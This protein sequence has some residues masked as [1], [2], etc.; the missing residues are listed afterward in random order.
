MKYS[1]HPIPQSIADQVR[2]TMRSPGY[3]HPAH[4][5]VARGTGPCRSC[6]RPFRVGEDERILFTY[7]PFDD[8]G[9]PS[10]GPVF[11]HA[12]SCQRHEGAALPSELEAIPLVLEA[13]SADGRS[14]GRLA[15]GKRDPETAMTELSL[16]TGAEYFHLR[17]AEAGCFI[18]RVELLRIHELV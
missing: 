1:V 16:D 12:E 6:L 11:I 14:L 7:Q 18:A 17:H 10:P 3:G 2:S 9:L 5:E 13:F 15:L 4:R 8:L